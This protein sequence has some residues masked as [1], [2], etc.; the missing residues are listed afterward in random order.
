MGLLFGLAAGLLAGVVIMAGWSYAMIRRSEQRILKA[1]HHSFLNGVGQDELKRL[2]NGSF[3]SWLSFPIF[4]RV[5]WLNK[6]L[7]RVW[8]YVAQAASD[9]IRSSVE[10]VLEE[11]RPVGITSLKFTKLFLGNVA[12]QIE[13]IRLQSLKEGQLTMDL[14]FRWAGDP[15]IILS[16]QTL[17]GANLPIQLKNMKFFANVR[18]IFQLE[19]EIPCISGFVVALLAKPSHVIKY[20]LKVIGGSLSAV[21]GL[22]DMIKETVETAVSDT[23]Q[24]PHR[25]LVTI[26]QHPVDLSDLERNLE[27]KLTVT[28][29]GAKDL[30]NMEMIGKSDP[31]VEVYVRV[32][33]KFRTRTIK[34]NL[35][36]E[37]N[38]TFELDVEDQET[39]A[40]V[41]K[42]F[43]EDIGHDKS[44]GVVAYPVANLKPEENVDLTLM[45]LPSLDIENVRNTRDRGSIMATI[46]YH[47]YTKEE[48]TVAMEKEKALLAAKQKAKEEGL[49]NRT[50]D[51]IGGAV[52]SAGKLVGTGVDMVGSGAGVVGT[53]IGRAGKFMT[54][55]VTGLRS[56]KARRPST[57]NSVTSTPNFPSS[58]K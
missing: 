26:A 46:K 52:G 27:G 39:Q 45:L 31:Y 51:A 22:S 9:V 28:I 34:N 42:V 56:K 14:D 48:Q 8:P 35:H 38:E 25:I 32:L 13:G 23:L 1:M 47:V 12:P 15:S 54:R 2:C 49:V 4:E 57:E 6:Q 3:P 33:F 20:T 10:P 29:K 21:P 11:Y 43:D 50:T 24:W 19:D 37:W 44:L 36:P 53:R 7:E 16:V 30:K 58:P 17:V 41:L 40:L 5:K 55:S 18:V